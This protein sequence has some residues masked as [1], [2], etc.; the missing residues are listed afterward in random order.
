MKG[1][2]RKEKGRER[3]RTR[4]LKIQFQNVTQCT[5]RHRKGY[6][7]LLTKV[8]R[9]EFLSGWDSLEEVLCSFCFSA[10]SFLGFCIYK[11]Y[12]YFLKEIYIHS[13]KLERHRKIPRESLLHAHHLLVTSTPPRRPLH[14]CQFSN[15]S[16][17][18]H[19]KDL[20]THSLV[21]YLFYPNGC[22]R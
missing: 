10:F 3:S 13:L 4:K 7:R 11:S 15:V 16:F 22:I 1:V 8:V 20:S 18:G 19:F 2:G 14:C 9:E 21:S 5:C 6:G 17:Q 12:I